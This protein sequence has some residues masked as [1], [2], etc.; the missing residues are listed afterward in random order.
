MSLATLLSVTST[1]VCWQCAFSKL[2]MD[3]VTP[4][5]PLNWKTEI[6]R[7]QH[8]WD[9]AQK[10]WFDYIFDPHYDVTFYGLNGGTDIPALGIDT[11]FSS[12]LSSEDMFES[13][14]FAMRLG[15]RFFHTD[16]SY[17][18]FEHIAR[19]I[20]AVGLRRSSL[21]LS[22]TIGPAEYGYRSTIDAVTSFA[23][24]MELKSLNLCLMNGPEVIWKDEEGQSLSDEQ[25]VFEE[26]VI[27]RLTWMALESLK[28]DGICQNLGVSHFE[29]KH[30]E[31]LMD[32]A[33][34][35]PAVNMIEY[36][37]FNQRTKLK[38]YMVR[39]RLTVISENVL[40]PTHDGA[41]LREKVVRELA[42]KYSKT[43]SQIVL[44]W[45]E[46]QAIIA[47][48][49]DSRKQRIAD[50]AQIFD[51]EMEYND[52]SKINDLNTEQAVSRNLENV[53]TVKWSKRNENDF[54]YR[55]AKEH[56]DMMEHHAQTYRAHKEAQRVKD[57][58]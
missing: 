56:G 52:I 28:E 23:K 44:K 29:R 42:E 39:E 50:N 30:I 35:K 47:V 10:K 24:E 37:P 34:C 32:F 5:Y 31:E 8:N 40:D 58:L 14:V 3:G 19:A 6:E 33:K 1:L 20:G 16:L 9:V 54:R 38:Q 22:L 2:N 27:R 17:H 41:L 55:L 21:F 48:P 11:K 53:Q 57:E 43:P 49:A 15:Y 36:H 13:L 12:D 26:A 46:Q 18:N 7:V 51:F 45:A 4:D 25:R